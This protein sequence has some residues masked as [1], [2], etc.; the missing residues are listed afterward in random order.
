MDKPITILREEFK[1]GMAEL[2][3]GSGLPYFLIEDVLKDY[4]VQVSTFARQQYEID[5]KTYT[6]A[7]TAENAQHDN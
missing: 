3:N 1:R 7:A 2:I 5:L 6:D 4:L